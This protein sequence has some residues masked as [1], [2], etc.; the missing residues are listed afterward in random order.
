MRRNLYVAALASLGWL[1]VRSGTRPDR[2]RYPCQRAALA[3]TAIVAP[4][5][6]S[7]LTAAGWHIKHW[8]AAYA[9]P[10]LVGAGVLTA[11]Y[12]G[13]VAHDYFFPPVQPLSGHAVMGPTAPMPRVVRVQDSRA[14]SWDFI[15]QYYWQHV[16]QGAVDRMVE[17]GIQRLTSATNAADGWRA[18]MTGYAA[19]DIVALKINCNDCWNSNQNEIDATPHVI[20]AVIRGL[21][22]MGVPEADIHVIEPT[23]GGMPR[24]RILYQYY[25]DLIHALYP[26]VQIFDGADSTFRAGGDAARLTFPDGRTDRISDLIVN[27][28][29]LINMP[30]L[31]AINP[32]WGISGAIKNH[33]GS[34][35]FPGRN[36]AT[37]TSVAANPFV[38]INQNPHIRDK[39][40]LIVADGL[41]G[42]WTGIHFFGSGE[43]D[44]VP[45]RWQIFGNGAPNS[46]FFATDSVA[47]D[48]VM[49]DLVAAERTARR[50][51]TM[52]DPPLH[53]AAS[54]GLGV[55]EHGTL[56]AGQSAPNFRYTA[57]DYQTV[58]LPAAPSCS[59]GQTRA[60]TTPQSCPGT[61]TCSSGIWGV[62]ADTP[63]DNCP[64]LCTDGQT[65]SCTTAQNCPGAETCSGGIWGSCVDSPGDGCPATCTSG[66]IRSCTTAQGCAGSQVCQ[67]N[68]WMACADSIGDS[69]P[70]GDL[71]ICTTPT[72]LPPCLCLTPAE[73]INTVQAWYGGTITLR[74][75]IFTLRLWRTNPSC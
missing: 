55:H 71:P 40:R 19:G 54:A 9:T 2:L 7:G 33:Q 8:L 66:Q 74:E 64:P 51:G 63:N 46:L 10:L 31:K 48:S 25:Y 52:G 12:A 42:T 67:A 34:I 70:A 75:F 58:S 17:E 35:Q 23:E 28:D 24:Q 11:V 62:C 43:D 20:N 6:L 32:N 18:I 50:L 22:S 27:A 38:T 5:L 13:L 3:H 73:L 68:V 16:D 36:H 56:D 39:T 30:L 41:F 45:N 49:Q 21:Q 72:N 1:L 61:E 69:C 44:D 60:C 57:I 15:G 14:T 65:R 47:V 53:A 29:H 37:G 59:S 26:G 4:T